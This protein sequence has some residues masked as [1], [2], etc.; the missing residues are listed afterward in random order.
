LRAEFSKSLNDKTL[1]YFFFDFNDPELQQ[2]ECMIRSVLLQLA[3]Q[4]KEVFDRLSTLY[5]SRQGHGNVSADLVSWQKVLFQILGSELAYSDICIVI[6]GLDE[7]ADREVLG[8]VLNAIAPNSHHQWFLASQLAS[9]DGILGFPVR[10]DVSEVQMKLE[11]VD[12]D[13]E[14]YVNERLE[15]DLRLRRLSSEKKSAIKEALIEKS[16]GM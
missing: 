8:L 11:N 14:T 12:R 16:G 6:D 5:G 13:I 3:I 10:L 1:A 7:C 15:Q 2:S 9:D 4:H